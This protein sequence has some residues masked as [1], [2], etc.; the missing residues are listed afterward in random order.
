MCEIHHSINNINKNNIPTDR[1]CEGIILKL[2]QIPA[3]IS[4]PSLFK[5]ATKHIHHRHVKKVDYLIV[6]Q[7][8][9]EK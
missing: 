1:F 2:Q 8:K 4:C 3:N 7:Q 6:H 9:V 5:T